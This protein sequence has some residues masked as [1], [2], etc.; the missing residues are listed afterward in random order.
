MLV[1]Y[2][3]ESECCCIV[4][5]GAKENLTDS[6]FL[7]SPY[8][9]F[10][11]I[12]PPVMVSFLITAGIFAVV[13]I[14]RFPFVAIMT[15]IFSVV[16]WML[17][18]SSCCCMQNQCGMI[19]TGVFGI[20]SA[21][22]TFVLAL[23]LKKPLVD[24]D[25]AF[26]D[27][28]S[29]GDDSN[30]D[31]YYYN[32]NRN[33]DNSNDCE[34]RSKFLAMLYII[35]GVIWL[36]GSIHLFVFACCVHPKKY[37]KNNKDKGEDTPTRNLGHLE[38]G[39]AVAVATPVLHTLP[40]GQQVLLAAQ[41]NRGTDSTSAPIEKPTFTPD[42]TM[43]NSE[44]ASSSRHSLADTAK[45]GKSSNNY[46]HQDHEVNSSSGS[47]SDDEFQ[48]STAVTKSGKAQHKMKY[49]ESESTLSRSS[50]WDSLLTACM[51]T[52]TNTD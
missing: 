21:I 14:V 44:T 31:Y 35:V 23:R 47:E 6:N 27:A 5:K 43:D 25:D 33:N 1:S 4:L 22:F 12:C 8:R 30:D 17:F 38:E 34:D 41:H 52:R 16:A 11:A 36:V 39:Q 40:N 48:G 13:L 50:F 51:Y 18:M 20:L 3:T 37:G 2:R 26:C 19:T 9:N 49:N 7:Y 46:A 32:V 29:A 28:I 24:L 42:E 10:N 45:R 15:G